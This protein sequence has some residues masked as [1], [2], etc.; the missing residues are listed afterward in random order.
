MHGRAHDRAKRRGTRRDDFFS[1]RV[2]EVEERGCQD[3]AYPAPADCVK[4]ALSHLLPKYPDMIVS[5]INAGANVSVD[6][7]YSGTVSAAT[8]GALAGIPALAVSV[9]DYHP[10]E[11]SAQAAFTTELLERGFWKTFPRQCV[12]NLNFPCRKTD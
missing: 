8:E 12:L 7:L 2:K 6:V 9:D 11:L 3:W 1:L 10:E 5:G 4:L